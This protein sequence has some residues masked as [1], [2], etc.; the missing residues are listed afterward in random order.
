M[1]KTLHSAGIEVILDVVYNHTGEGNQL[2]PDAVAPRHRQ[3]LLLPLNRRA[4]ALLRD[5]TG[6]GNTLNLEHPRVLQLVMDSL[7]YWVEEMHVDGFRF[8]LASALAREAGKVEHLGGFF[9]AIRPGPGAQPRQADRR[10]VGPRRRRLPGRQLPARLGR[11]ER[12]VPRRH[13]RLL[14]RRRRRASASS[15]SGSPAR[16]DLY[17][18]AGKRPH[19][20]INFVTAH[21]GFTL[22]DLVS[23][24][25]KHNEANGEDNRDGTRQQPV[26]ELRRRRADRRSRDQRAARAPEAQPARHAAALAGRADA[27]GRRRARPHAAR[28]Q[29]RLLPGQ[30]DQLARLDDDA[31]ARALLAF[32]QPPD[33]AAPRPPGLPPAQFLP[34]ASRSQATPSART[35]VAASP[36]A[37]R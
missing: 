13:A 4:A 12:P 7:R 37:A 33:R 22:H 19:A 10:A 32:V 16:S 3:R 5:Y 15:R 34:A 28:Q 29:Q 25:D 27:A 1:V 2:G 11:V 23:Y 31:G 24:N 14:E 36:T 6:C 8:D 18:A 9:D 26:V 30:R 17:D 21:D 35:C 20:S